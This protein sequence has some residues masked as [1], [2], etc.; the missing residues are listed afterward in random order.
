MSLTID[1]SHST[2][3]IDPPPARDIVVGVADLKFS[4]E[5]ATALATYAL[6]SCLGITFYDVRR[7]IGGMLHAMLPD[8]SLHHGQRVKVPMFLDT[9]VEEV[10]HGFTQLGCSISQLECKVFGGAQVMSADKF[11][12][13]GDRNIKTFRELTTKLGL[14]VVVAE[15]GGQINRTIKLYIDTGKVSVRTPN[16]PL[17][18]R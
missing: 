9:G 5:S 4:K 6:G 10:L 13:I 1:K 14:R 2:P 7:K 12:S 15:T 11:F 16:Q 17:F 3:S 8:S 18:W